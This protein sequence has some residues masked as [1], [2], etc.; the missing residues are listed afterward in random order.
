MAFPS[1]QSYAC[2]ADSSGTG[3]ES[4]KMTG[5]GVWR[6]MART[7]RSPRGRMRAGLALQLMSTVGLTCSITCARSS[8]HPGYKNALL[9]W[10][11]AGN[12][13]CALREHESHAAR[14]MHRQM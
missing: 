4:A 10:R 8:L 7:A 14:F 3:D 11:D 12:P 13:V 1:D 9:H 6:L 2:A 5:R